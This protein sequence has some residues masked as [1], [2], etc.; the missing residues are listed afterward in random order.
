M[1]LA[2]QGLGFRVWRLLSG[3]GLRFQDVWSVGFACREKGSGFSIQGLGL[4][5][6]SGL[7]QKASRSQGSG[8]IRGLRL[9]VQLGLT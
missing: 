4:R 9:G 3:L 7:P 1:G 5:V 2:A 6:Q 8:M